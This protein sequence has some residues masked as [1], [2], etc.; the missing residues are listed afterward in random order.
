VRDGQG[1]CQ[2]G[3]LQLAGTEDIFATLKLLFEYFTMNSDS[4]MAQLMV[5]PSG[6][7]GLAAIDTR[8]AAE[9]FSSTSLRCAYISIYMTELQL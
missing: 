5:A 9:Y 6:S 1:A 2:S 3:W 7:G 4:S 8:D